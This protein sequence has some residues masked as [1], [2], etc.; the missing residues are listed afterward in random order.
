MRR[1]K[2]PVAGTPEGDAAIE[3][4]KKALFVWQGGRWR[5]H[6]SHQEVLAADVAKQVRLISGLLLGTI[7]GI[8]AGVVLGI[9]TLGIGWVLIPV[10]AV[11]GGCV[12]ALMHAPGVPKPPL[13]VLPEG[14]DGVTDPRAARDP[15]WNESDWSERSEAARM[16]AE[17]EAGSDL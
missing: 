5:Q 6:A 1:I 17:R 10:L 3:K 13:C 11:V 14:A 12:G 8:G 16:A 9:V 7:I 4:N 15:A 2:L